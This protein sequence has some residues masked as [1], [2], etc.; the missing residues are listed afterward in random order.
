[1]SVADYLRLAL[2]LNA[3]SSE[4]LNNIDIYRSELI[5]N[6]SKK[7]DTNK[8]LEPFG[9]NKFDLSDSC[10]LFEPE[11]QLPIQDIIDFCYD[12]NCQ[13]NRKDVNYH[14]CPNCGVE[15]L[16]EDISDMNNSTRLSYNGSLPMRISGRTMQSKN[17]SHKLMGSSS[18]YDALKRRKLVNM[19]LRQVYNCPETEETIPSYILESA[20]DQYIKLQKKEKI[21]KRAGGLEAVLTG[22]VASECK[23]N[24]IA[25]KPNTITQILNVDDNRLS[26]GC[27]ILRGYAKTGSITFLE[28]TNDDIQYINQYFERLGLN[29]FEKYK[30]FVIR[31]IEETQFKK[32][33]IRT[34]NTRPTTRIAGA[35]LLLCEELTK[36][37]MLADSENKEKEDFPYITKDT[38]AHICKISK[39]TIGRYTNLVEN[40]K[41]IEPIMRLYRDFEFDI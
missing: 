9:N 32:I 8:D 21:V 38:I 14:I 5:G 11:L 27:K 36:K 40:N 22:L 24:G 31:L 39:S 13:M 12:C 15:V 7:P 20:A 28:G 35:I 34:N 19:L 37:G 30:E 23:R 3:P 10:N 29:N 25:R 16:D 1:M 4:V 17:L 33:Q 41:T 26:I 6:E 2:T 18:N